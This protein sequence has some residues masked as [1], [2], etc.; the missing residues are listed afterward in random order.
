MAFEFQTG[1]PQ[2]PQTDSSDESS[3]SDSEDERWT[4]TGKAVPGERSNV[5]SMIHSISSPI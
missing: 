2:T 1:V 5:C 4:P 3:F